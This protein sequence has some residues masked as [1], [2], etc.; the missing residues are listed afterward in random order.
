MY[1][2]IT[3]QLPERIKQ[4]KKKKKKALTILIAG[5]QECIAVRNT[6]CTATLEESGAI[7]HETKHILIYHPAIVPVGIYPTHFIYLFIF[8]YFI[9]IFI[10]FY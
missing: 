6:K 3:T 9:F 1:G 10:Y 4:K 7:S 5:V 8:L 2:D